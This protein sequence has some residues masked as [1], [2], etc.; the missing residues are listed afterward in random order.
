[1]WKSTCS[2]LDVFCLPRQAGNSSHDTVI[3]TQLNS[4]H[5]QLKMKHICNYRV[6]C[7][8]SGLIWVNKH[9]VWH[10][11]C[12]LMSQILC[13]MV[14]PTSKFLEFLTS[15]AAEGNCLSHMSL[16]KDSESPMLCFMSPA[17]HF[18]HVPTHQISQ[19]TLPWT[20]MSGDEQHAQGRGQW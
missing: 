10:L 16:C 15:Q 17:S 4:E 8:C 14:Q 6:G 12:L 5:M 20:A 3:K 7:R 1:M 18:I 2:G 9:A 13:K 19:P 11:I